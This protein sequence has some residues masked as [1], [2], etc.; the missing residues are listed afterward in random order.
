[1]TYVHDITSLGCSSSPPYFSPKKECNNKLIVELQTM[2]GTPKAGYL[3]VIQTTDL[4]ENQRV[5][6]AKHG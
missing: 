3:G 1:M 5:T 6:A 2:G 4:Q